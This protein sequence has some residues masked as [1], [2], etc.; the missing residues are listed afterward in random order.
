MPERP[1]FLI[2]CCDQLRADCLGCEGNEVAR[3]P[4]IDS[5]AEEGVRFSRAYVQ[6]P[7]CS[8]SRATML[9]GRYPRSHGLLCNGTPLP[10][11]EITL[12]QVLGE[13]GYSTCACGKV[14]LRPHE[15]SLEDHTW[16][17]EYE[18]GGPYYGF[19]RVHLT[20]D[21]KLGGYLRWIDDE[22]PEWS[23]E[24]RDMLDGRSRSGSVE[25]WRSG[26]PAELHQSRWIAERSIDFLESAGDRP[27]FLW[28]SFV[29]PHHPF[30]PP[31]PYSD[32]YDR[33][34]IPV[35]SRPDLSGFGPHWVARQRASADRSAEQWR[36]I[37]ALYLGMISLIDDCVGRVLEAL[38]ERGLAEN[39][40]V[41]FVNDHGELLGH[42]GMLLK[43][44][45]LLESLIRQVQLWR[46]PGIR[47]GAVDDG[48]A[49]SVDIA[50]TVL[51]I[52]GVDRPGGMQGVSLVPR[53][54]GEAPGRDAALVQFSPWT[55]YDG[56][57]FPGGPD[58]LHLNA[59]V[60]DRHKLVHYGGEPPGELFDLADDPGETRNLYPDADSAGLRANLTQRLLDRLSETVDPLPPRVARY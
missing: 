56:G 28:C 49:E 37:I 27:F 52:A 60:T 21:Y 7:L 29:D 54:Q 16:I 44:P 36:E 5:I 55:A 15:V 46:G 19:Q 13:A 51:Q 6:N 45:F 31:A 24:A 20:D 12:P 32:M 47:R 4:N 22:H 26:L 8:P 2:F 43:G 50:P 59:L 25:A 1:N 10:E 35:P 40:V 57:R 39:T 3:T 48:L 33:S 14:H 41:G 42:H 53:L 17:Q 58:R 34:A 11:R 38:Q 18:G 30:N 23:D 9:T